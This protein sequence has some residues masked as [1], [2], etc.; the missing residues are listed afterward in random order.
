M[1][2]GSQLHVLGSLFQTPVAYLPDSIFVSCQVHFILLHWLFHVLS[3]L[4]LGCEY[5]FRRQAYTLF[6]TGSLKSPQQLYHWAVAVAPTR[7]ILRARGRSAT[8]QRHET[9]M[10]SQSFLVHNWCQIFSRNNRLS[11]RD[12]ASAGAAHVG[13]MNANRP[14]PKGT[15][16]VRACPYADKTLIYKEVEDV[17]FEGKSAA[18]RKPLNDTFRC[19]ICCN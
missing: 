9:C 15:K 5:V 14:L 18:S 3:F 7:P 16:V 6:G 8:A 13:R 4:C 11:K 12:T 2:L 10:E 17:R 19:R 1:R